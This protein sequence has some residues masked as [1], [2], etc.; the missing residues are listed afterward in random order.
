MAATRATQQVV[1]VLAG[2]QAE[3]LRVTQQ[4]VQALAIEIAATR[5]TQMFSTGLVAAGPD[6][7]W[8]EC[9]SFLDERFPTDLATDPTSGGPG[10]Q[11]LQTRV[12][13]GF[14]QRIAEWQEEL[15]RWT[16]A[17]SV[18]THEQMTRI[19]SLYRVAHGP[20]DGFRFQDPFDYA[21][22][23]WSGEEPGQ[24]AATDM[25]FGTG[26]GETVQFQLTVTRSYGAGTA[27]K[28]IYKPVAPILVAVN[29]VAVTSFALDDSTG[30]IT[31]TPRV[32]AAGSD[33]EVLFTAGKWV[34]RSTATS[35]LGFLAGDRIRVAGSASNDTAV[36]AGF[37]T[38][39]SPVPAGAGDLK[40]SETL[41]TE[42]AGAS[43]TVDV[44]PAPRSG[45]S[46]KWG[47]EYDKPVHFVEDD[48]DVEHRE[49]GT[50]FAVLLEEL[51]RKDTLP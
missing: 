34:L 3:G 35:W 16:I 10:Y 28:T 50:Q 40:V 21:T 19:A 29:E 47:G 8:A 48:L 20:R 22:W 9:M 37:Y 31:F 5:V 18:L 39:E 6:L 27:D 12:R 15:G 36:P 32:S 43:I 26:D 51:R 4:I 41:I 33:I 44:H 38:V 25:R 1:Q 7:E 23:Q 2:S 13:S 49:Q 42:A 45:Q 30:V 11:T 17:G 14:S 24:A 46:V